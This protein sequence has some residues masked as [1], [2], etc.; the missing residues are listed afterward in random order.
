MP[1]LQSYFLKGLQ[2][3][4]PNGG[5]FKATEKEA[6]A[7]NV[8]ERVGELDNAVKSLRLAM[9]FAMDVKNT[10]ED[11]P[12]VYRYH[13]EN[14][15]L[16]L[17]GLV[18]RAHRLVGVSLLLSPSKLKKIG[19]NEFVAKSIASEYPELLECLKK[20]ATI[21]AKHKTS[22]NEVAHSTAFST[23]ELGLFSSV[24][25]LNLKVGDNTQINELMNSYFLEGSAE[26]ALL[27]AEMVT[28]IE[29]LLDALVP[30][31]EHLFAG[32]S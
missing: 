27:V 21:A 32:D 5:Q 26:L 25:S 3:V 8:F 14:F 19:A 23:R 12:E 16:R 31:H 30:I 22:R 28:G 10:Y 20:L 24:V 13:Y 29:K 18:D 7:A 17:T 6:Y 11:A 2:E 1:Y 4:K 15:L 9:C